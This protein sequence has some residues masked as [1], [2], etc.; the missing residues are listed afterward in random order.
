MTALALAAVGGL[1]RK[2]GVTLSAN[3]LV[4]LVSSGEGGQ[5]RLNFD[6][7]ETHIYLLIIKARRAS[8]KYIDGP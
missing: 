1:H 5:S 4:A 8:P 3:H 2:S 6:S 7:T